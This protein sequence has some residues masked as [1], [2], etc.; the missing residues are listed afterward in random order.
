MVKNNPSKEKV[1]KAAS[2]LFFQ[3]GFNGTSVRDIANKA[4]VN[5]SA[6][7]YYFNSKQGLLEYAVTNYYENY[8]SS[9]EDTIKQSET[10]TPLEKLHALILAIIH[11]K[12]SNYQLSCFIQRELSLDSVFVREITVTYLAKEN[13]YL[14]KF[15]FD[16][17]EGRVRSDTK[18]YLLMQLKGMLITPYILH[19]EWKDQVIGDYSHRLFVKNY[20]KIIQDWIQ[21]INQNGIGTENKVAY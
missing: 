6:I 3:K 11:Y 12:Q 21:L 14:K 10:L 2:S 8:L 17:L 13:F 4:S 1:I 9:I 19:K 5:I 15:F 18:H 16:A 20:T 7:N